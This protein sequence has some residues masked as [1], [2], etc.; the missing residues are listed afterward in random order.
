MV[1]AE[2]KLGTALGCDKGSLPSS[3]M[4]SGGDRACQREGRSAAGEAGGCPLGLTVSGHAQRQALLQAA[5][6]ASVAAR[7]VNGAVLLTGAGVGHVAVLAPAE[8]ALGRAGR[9]QAADL[10]QARPRP[11]TSGRPTPHDRSL[12]S[13]LVLGVTAVCPGITYPAQDKGPP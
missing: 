10:G 2:P 12:F 7:A 5:V 8:E 11:G 6:L 1:L 9:H 13:P 3:T 4:D